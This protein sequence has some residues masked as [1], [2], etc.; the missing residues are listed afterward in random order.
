MGAKFP[1]HADGFDGIE[2]LA[3]HRAEALHQVGQPLAQLLLLGCALARVGLLAELLA[4]LI[5]EAAVEQA[6]LLP[7]QRVEIAH[8]LHRLGILAL[9]A[10]LRLGD[11]AYP[12]A[13]RD[14]IEERTGIV[15]GSATIYC[16]SE[17]HY[18]IER[19]AEILEQ[20]V[21]ALRVIEA[22]ARASESGGVAEVKPVETP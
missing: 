4:L 6:L 8:H 13:L 19:A 3:A 12:V 20:V 11:N 15:G 1:F 14:E 7:A 5:A 17:A 22:M 2:R 16:S 18:S 10:V 21:A 9:L